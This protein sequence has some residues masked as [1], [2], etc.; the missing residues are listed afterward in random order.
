M[1]A[2]D[3]LRAARSWGYQLQDLDVG[4][5]AR[6]TYDVLVIDFPRGDGGGIL[7]PRELARLR[8]KPDGSRRL[9]LADMNIG[10]AED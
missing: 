9:V 4:K 8:S 1:S 10:E 7:G 6:T 2:R 3:L 5:L